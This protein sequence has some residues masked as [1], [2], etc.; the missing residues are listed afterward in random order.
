MCI[1]IYIYIYNL[2]TYIHLSLL[3]IY[4]YIPIVAIVH[5]ACAPGSV[6]DL[7]RQKTLPEIHDVLKQTRGEVP[8]INK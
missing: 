4:I 2:Y 7:F 6:D 8:H 3:Y 5:S 1:Y